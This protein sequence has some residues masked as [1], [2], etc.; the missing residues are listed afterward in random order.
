MRCVQAQE[1]PGSKAIGKNKPPARPSP[2]VSPVL[3]RFAQHLGLPDVKMERTWPSTSLKCLDPPMQR[4]LLH[5]ITLVSVKNFR[6]LF[7]II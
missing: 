1:H 7:P 5:E 2:A 6:F 4:L 3:A